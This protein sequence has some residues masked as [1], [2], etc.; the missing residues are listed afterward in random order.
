[1]PLSFIICGLIWI[2]FLFDKEL[3]YRTVILPLGLVFL[4]GFFVPEFAL[5]IVRINPILFGMPIVISLVTLRF[6][7]AKEVLDFI[8]AALTVIVFYIILLHVNVYASLTLVP[9]ILLLVVITGMLLSKN[10][11]TQFCVFVINLLYIMSAFYMNPNKLPIFLGGIQSIDFICISFVLVMV[12]NLS[13]RY[14]KEKK[15][16]KVT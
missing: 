5:G 12:A 7:N 6:A 16:E 15:H 1:M 13:R 11:G 8:T 9:Y 14:I 3:K 10:N 4:V 2:Y